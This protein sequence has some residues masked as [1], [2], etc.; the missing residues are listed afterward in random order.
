MNKKIKAGKRERNAI[1]QQI[2][3]ESEGYFSWDFLWDDYESDT[4]DYIGNMVYWFEIRN[5]SRKLI[6]FCDREG[7]LIC[8]VL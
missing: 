1:R 5:A 8:R 4:Y 7:K 2:K 6:G 3:E